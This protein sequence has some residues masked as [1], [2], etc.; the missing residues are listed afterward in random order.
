MADLQMMLVDNVRATERIANCPDGQARP[1]YYRGYRS[2]P[3]RTARARS[4]ADAPLDPAL[5]L[6]IGSDVCGRQNDN[7][8]SSQPQSGKRPTTGR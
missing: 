3:M 7:L 2:P 5:R 8:P 4:I 1:S 6:C